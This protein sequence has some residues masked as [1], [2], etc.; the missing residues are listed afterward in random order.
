[1]DHLWQIRMIGPPQQL[2]LE[3]YATL[4]FLAGKSERIGLS[5]WVGAV[6]YREPRCWPKP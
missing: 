1:M 6:V 4:G 2:M 3:A 5:A